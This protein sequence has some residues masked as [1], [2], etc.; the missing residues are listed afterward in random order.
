M[1]SPTFEKTDRITFINTLNEEDFEKVISYAAFL[2]HIEE[3]EEAED[4]E[5]YEAHKNDPSISLEDALK[6][7]GL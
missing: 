1:S 2:R 5:Y 3:Q 7:L 4:A 6:E